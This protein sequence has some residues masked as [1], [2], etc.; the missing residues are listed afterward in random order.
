MKQDEQADIEVKICEANK[1]QK[2][3]KHIKGEYLG[4]NFNDIMEEIRAKK[5]IKSEYIETNFKVKSE[6]NT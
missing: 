2:A 5:C 1:V 6:V 4:S 3:M